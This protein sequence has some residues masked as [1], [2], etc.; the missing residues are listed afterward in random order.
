M[1][2]V[3][4]ESKFQVLKST[5]YLFIGGCICMNHTKSFCPFKPFYLT[6]FILSL[7]FIKQIHSFSD[8]HLSNYLV[9]D[10]LLPTLGDWSDHPRGVLGSR[11]SLGLF[12]IMII[13]S[14]NHL[15]HQPHHDHQAHHEDESMKGYR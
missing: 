4:K 13:Q 9:S 12:F 15:H 3:L 1:T 8:N 2:P 6:Q 10:H 5:F 14:S 7:I 11:G